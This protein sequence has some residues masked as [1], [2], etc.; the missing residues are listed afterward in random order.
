MR[1]IY[2]FS[3]PRD[4]RT[5]KL[6]I[7]CAN[8]SVPK[9]ETV[10]PTVTYKIV[11]TSFLARGGDGFTFDK[12]VID[13]MKTEGELFIGKTINVNVFFFYL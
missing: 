3:R 4:C 1:V 6:E 10:Q 7:L 8:C 2:N 5:E 9:Y 11:T 13:S 12:E